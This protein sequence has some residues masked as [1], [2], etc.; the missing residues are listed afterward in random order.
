MDLTLI[1]D[2]PGPGTYLNQEIKPHKES[3]KPRFKKVEPAIKPK[4]ECVT[5]PDFG[6]GN[7]NAIERKQFINNI[8]RMIS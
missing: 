1:N 3:S 8:K 4:T 5:P 7:P 2:F 6:L